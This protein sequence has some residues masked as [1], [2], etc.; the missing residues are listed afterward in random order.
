MKK[1]KISNVRAEAHGAEL[2]IISSEK[3]LPDAVIADPVLE[4]VFLYYFGEKGGDSMLLYELKKV[5]VRPVNRI[6]LLIY[7]STIIMVT[8]LAAGF[9]VSG[10]FSSEFAFKSRFHIFFHHSM[11]GTEAYDPRSQQDLSCCPVSTGLQ[12][13]FI[14]QLFF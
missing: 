12:C 7:S 1:Y 6:T 8:V 4:D 9:L 10:I 13:C 2:R 11:G 14:R 5:L 3:P